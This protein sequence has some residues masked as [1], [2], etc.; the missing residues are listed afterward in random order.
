MYNT[1]LMFLLGIIAGL[2]VIV[3]M[4]KKFRLFPRQGNLRYPLF[5][6]RI[7]IERF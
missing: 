3:F 6:R 1:L 5:H 2:L 4:N 7:Q